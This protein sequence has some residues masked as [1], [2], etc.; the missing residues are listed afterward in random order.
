M[1]AADTCTVCLNNYTKST[2]KEIRC[3]YCS[4]GFCS[5]CVKYYCLH[6]N[7]DPHCMSCKKG[8]SREFIE[9]SL[10]ST[11]ITGEYK[12]HRENILF[13][14]EKSRLPEAQLIIERHNRAKPYIEER[15][16]L[17][18]KVRELMDIVRRYENMRTH[19]ES[20]I[21]RLQSGREE[22]ENIEQI[23]H[24]YDTPSENN[25][26]IRN[27]KNDEE[28]DS[29]RVFIMSCPAADCRGFLSQAYKCGICEVY[30]CSSCHELKKERDDPNHQCNPD[31][32]KTVAAIKKECRPCPQCS[33]H[34]YRVHG[35]NQMFCTICKTSFDWQTGKRST[36]PVHNP[37]YHEWLAQT[38][39]TRHENGYDRTINHCGRQLTSL[40]DIAKYAFNIR[41][42]DYTYNM[43]NIRD[44][45]NNNYKI[46]LMDRFLNHIRHVEMPRFQVGQNYTDNLSLNIEYLSKQ[47][48]EDEWKKT[49]Q[50]REKRVYVKNEIY[51]R[52]SAFADATQECIQ[53]LQANEILES[54]LLSSMRNG[55]LDDAQ[56]L[57]KQKVISLWTNKIQEIEN[58]IHLYNTSME[59]LKKRI[60]NVVY[61]I[62]YEKDGSHSE[63]CDYKFKS[64]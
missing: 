53:D 64:L 29:K 31:T 46:I 38:G 42:E 25:P 35:C 45:L 22:T 51:Q 56:I 57:H 39:Q 34:I 19:L 5:E 30:V 40:F 3:P 14:R 47:I 1:A 7:E 63:N 55:N 15:Q 16:H 48:T 23:L 20:Q 59:Q 62:V 49:L 41:G 4:I 60:K 54:K 6:N 26:V 50:Q 44:I 28:Y 36:G 12:K 33:A 27:K 13:D 61:I 10:P 24:M 17:T 21:Q 52:M 32:V 58:L 43:R 8:W 2:R 11:W 18:V 9:I 37:H